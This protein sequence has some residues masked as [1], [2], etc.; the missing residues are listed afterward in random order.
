MSELRNIKQ[1]AEDDRPREKLISKGKSVLS[2]AE[3]LAILM[4]SGSQKETAVD[5]SKRILSDVS[6]NLLELSKLS[7]NDLLG[8][9]GV[10]EAKALS[11][12]AAL[13]LGKRCRV[14]EVA[15]KEKISGSRDVFEYF[16][17][18]L[19]DNQYEEFWVLFLN[20]A[21]K[22]LKKNIISQGGIAG[23]VA[24]PKKIFKAALENNA[25]SMILCH[26]HPSGNIK[27]SEADIKLTRKLKDAGTLMDISVLDHIII[28]DNT[29][30]SFADEGLM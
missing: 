17:N 16:Q 21:N 10:G 4:R 3:L 14:S 28:G 12:I 18:N 29:Y 13:E 27:P 2:D 20:R 24:D 9:S 22:I 19:A 30:F 11:I 26:N 23:T 5:L 15:V 25:S 7:L 1:W 8:Y 6:D